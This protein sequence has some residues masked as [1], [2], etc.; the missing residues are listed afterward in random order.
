MNSISSFM[1]L[2]PDVITEILD[3][4]K[5]VYW[6]VKI[7]E[8]CDAKVRRCASEEYGRKLIAHEKSLSGCFVEFYKVTR[9]RLEI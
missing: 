8:G 4:K 2:P 1:R 5:N 6:E 7:W 3:E 9:E